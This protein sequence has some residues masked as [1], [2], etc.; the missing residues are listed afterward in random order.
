MDSFRIT[1]RLSKRLATD[2]RARSIA[3]RHTSSDLVRIALQPGI[4]KSE[5]ALDLGGLLLA[6]AAWKDD[7]KGQTLEPID[8]LTPDQ[9]FF[10]GYGQSWCGQVRDESKRMR[11]TIDPILRKNIAPMVWSQTC[12]SF[13]RPSTARPARPW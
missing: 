3:Q 8:D 10:V 9:R 4:E 1:V 12:R 2:L 7:T 6:Y 13:S 5:P 11:A